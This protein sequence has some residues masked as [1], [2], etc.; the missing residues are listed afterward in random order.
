MAADGH[1]REHA[2][3]IDDR[4]AGCRTHWLRLAWVRAG[5]LRGQARGPD[6]S[7]IACL[8]NGLRRERAVPLQTSRARD[9]WQAAG[10]CPFPCQIGYDPA[11]EGAVNLAEARDLVLRL[12]FAGQAQTAGLVV[13]PASPDG[14][15]GKFLIDGKS[16]RVIHRYNGW[17]VAIS[18]GWFTGGYDRA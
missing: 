18:L 1:E 15:P 3:D 17:N 7:C 10:S 8:G 14:D 11:W 6:D 2:A 9:D 16:A 12:I 13:D 5:E 4:T